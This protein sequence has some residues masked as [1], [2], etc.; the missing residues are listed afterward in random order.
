MNPFNEVGTVKQRNENILSNK[1]APV[2]KIVFIT[3]ILKSQVIFKQNR[4]E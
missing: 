1:G 3:S 2:I 4:G